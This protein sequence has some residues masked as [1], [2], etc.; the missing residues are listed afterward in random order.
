MDNNAR[1]DLIE[2]TAQALFKAMIVEKIAKPRMRKSQSLKK[3]QASDMPERI[4]LQIL[5]RVMELFDAAKEVEDV[6]ER[7]S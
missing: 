5:E 2:E 6:T 7:L 4:K 3:L 1:T